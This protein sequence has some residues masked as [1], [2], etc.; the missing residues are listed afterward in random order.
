MNNPCSIDGELIQ[1]SVNIIK[2][3][4]DNNLKSVCVISGI[5]VES[6]DDNNNF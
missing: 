6:I 4:S 3:V 5:G 1:S 2:D